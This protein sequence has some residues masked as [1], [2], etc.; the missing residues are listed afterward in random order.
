MSALKRRKSPVL[1][2]VMA[3]FFASL[4]LRVVTGT[5]PALA[6]AESM[7]EDEPAAVESSTTTQL[8]PALLEALAEREARVAERERAIEDRL[9][10]LDIA[11]Q[12][13]TERLVQ[14]QEAE[15]SLAATLAT[16]QTANDGDITNLVAVY[17]S[18]KPA[19]AAALFEEMAPDFAAGFIARMRPDAAAAVLAGLEPATAYSIS[20]VIAGR[21]ANA[22]TE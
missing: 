18:M 12:E 20:V 10:A 8:S 13:L 6:L 17:E 15:A 22:P 9:L 1:Y 21:N 2:V 3:L 11:E 16:A 4:G 7:K 14:L 19:E 5:G